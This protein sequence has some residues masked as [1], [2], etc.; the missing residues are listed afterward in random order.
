MGRGAM[1][2]TQKGLQTVSHN[3]QNLNTEGYSRQRVT[4]KT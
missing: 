2:T 3:L 4:Q 1:Q